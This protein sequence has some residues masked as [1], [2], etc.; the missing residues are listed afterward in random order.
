M[1]NSK[2]LAV[3]SM[4][5][6]ATVVI[7]A[8]VGRTYAFFTV[9]QS[10]D[11]TYENYDYLIWSSVEPCVGVIGCCLPTLRPLFS[12]NDSMV[13][14]YYTGYA[15]NNARNRSPPMR[16]NSGT[17]IAL[18]NGS[19]LKKGTTVGRPGTFLEEGPTS[20]ECESESGNPRALF[21]A[22]PKLQAL[23][24]RDDSL[25]QSPVESY[26]TPR[27]WDLGRSGVANV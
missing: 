9:G 10:P 18:T 8:G 24:A 15:G 19:S 14:R 1:D 6:T 17:D 21:H 11:Y 22:T 25:C 7:I 23:D 26:D 27:R 5:L 13:S 2:K 3:G 12:D 4:L 20:A 16:T